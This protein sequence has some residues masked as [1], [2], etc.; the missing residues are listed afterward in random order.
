MKHKKWRKIGIALAIGGLLIPGGYYQTAYATGNGQKE[1]TD[2]VIDQNATG[3]ESKGKVRFLNATGKLS[4]QFDDDLLTAVVKAYNDEKKTNKAKEDITYSDLYTMTGVLDLSSTS[5]KKIP[6]EAFANCKFQEVKFPDTLETIGQSSFEH[7]KQLTKINIPDTL[8]E[9]GA[10]AFFDCTALAELNETN[11][12]PSKITNVGNQVF[13]SDSALKSVTIATDG[14]DPKVYQKATGIFA[15][16]SGLESIII[17]DGVSVIPVAAFQNSGEKAENGVTVSFGKDLTSILANAFENVNFAK[18]SK[19]D[20]SSCSALA[21][22]H[23]DAFE[24]AKNLTTVILPD[25]SSNKGGVEFDDR[26]FANTEIT[27]MNVAGNFKEEDSV[28]YIP[29][30]VTRLGIGCFYGSKEIAK[31]SLSPKVEILSDYLFDYCTSLAVIEQRVDKD[32]NCAVKEIGDCAF[33]GTAITNTEF[34][35]AMNQLETIGYQHIE[36]ENYSMNNGVYDGKGSSTNQQINQEGKIGT[37]PLGGVGD[38]NAKVTENPET[39]QKTYEGVAVGSEVFSDCYSLTKVVIPASVTSIAT[40]A[41]YHLPRNIDKIADN[42]KKTPSISSIEWQSDDQAGKRVIWS[43]AFQGNTAVTKIVLP[44][45]KKDELDIR[46]YAFSYDKALKVIKGNNTEDNVL[47][48]T[49][50]NLSKGVFYRCSA[51][52][53]IVVQNIA[54]KEESPAL[55]DYLF[56]HCTAMKKATL[57]ASIREIPKHCFYNVPLTSYSIGAENEGEVE[58]ISKIGNLAFLGN[59]FKTVDLSA[60]TGLSEIGAGAFAYIDAVNEKGEEG[61]NSKIYNNPFSISNAGGQIQ[62]VIL[63]DALNKEIN[64]SGALYLNSA[65]FYGNFY[66]STLTTT[67]AL[68]KYAEK[69]VKDGVFYVPSY[70]TIHDARAVFAAT[71]VSKTIWQVDIDPS[72]DKENQW[73]D[74]PMLLYAN[75]FM[76]KNSKDVLPAGNYVEN[77]GKGAFYASAVQ[78]ADLSQYTSLTKIGSGKLESGEDQYTGVFADCLL[79]NSVVLP[80]SKAEKFVL[81]DQTFMKTK[82][83]TLDAD[84]L[85]EEDENRQNVEDSL[86]IVDLGNIT[87]MGANAFTGCFKLKSIVLPDTL[88]EIPDNAFMNC[89]ALHN[90]DFGQVKKINSFAFQ[91]CK[92]L[93][94]SKQGDSNYQLPDT[95]ESIESSAFM[96]AGISGEKGLGTAVFGDKLTTISDSVF[97]S[98]ALTGVDFTNAKVLET[99]GRKA[100]YKSKLVNFEL[101]GTKV[102]TINSQVLA[103]CEKLESA[104]FGD[105]VETIA[106]GAIKGCPNFNSI[107]FASTTT[108][109]TGVFSGTET[110]NKEQVYTAQKKAYTIAV[111]VNA[112]EQ[113]IVAAERENVN[114]PYY[115]NK[116]GTSSLTHIVIGMPDETEDE[117]VK[118]FVKLHA[119]LSDGYYW[120]TP[121]KGNTYKIDNNTDYYEALAESRTTRYNKNDVDVVQLD[122]LKAGKYTIS[123]TDAMKFEISSEKTVTSTFTT[124]FNI[125]AQSLQYNVGIYKSKTEQEDSSMLYEQKIGTTEE[126]QATGYNRKGAIQCYYKLEGSDGKDA[127]AE[128]I[129]SYDVIVKSDDTAIVVPGSNAGVNADYDKET[130]YTTNATKTQNNVVTPRENNMYFW[131]VPTGVGSTTVTVYP[132]GHE[133]WKTTFTVNINSDINAIEVSVPDD[134]SQGAVVGNTF[135][136]FNSYT[137]LFDASVTSD[138]LDQAATVSNRGIAY[139]SDAP[140]YASVDAAGNVTILKADVRDKRVRITAAAQNA[141]NGKPVS[142]YVTVVIKGDPTATTQ[143]PTTQAPTTEKPTDNPNNANTSANQNS[144]NQGGNATDKK[145][146]VRTGQTVEDAASGT[147]VKVTKVAENG[148]GGEVAITTINN[149]NATKVSIPTTVMVEGVPYQVTEISSN[150]CSGFKK[151]KA[152]AIP[153][154]VKK[155]GDGAF[156]NCKKLKKVVIPKGVESIGSNA[157]YGCKSLKLITVKSTVLKSVGSNAFYGIHKKAKIKVPKKK[158]KVYK[159]I[160]SNKGQKKSVKIKK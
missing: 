121:K 129:D 3:N 24:G 86:E 155:I 130:G 57:P 4:D 49:I 31:V 87:E 6:D 154:S 26:A 107:T 94:F 128:W 152:V 23:A 13:G 157:F 35:L 68:E 149:K 91:N 133:D 105:E 145:P 32:K 50:L 8:K 40:R 83:A 9:L 150:L 14:S 60:Y 119:K 42:S 156:Q 90:V 97:A 22:F 136:I 11:A 111:I 84:D 117:S 103:G 127:N 146:S 118:E 43:G 85:K 61:Q 80:Q 20:F 140:E 108:V 123:V 139:T 153:A 98:S 104:S 82:N 29:D 71:A 131:L 58:K 39:K 41:F 124:L 120:Y 143:A 54:G 147:T 115:V 159:S 114:L 126:I 64:E 56:E 141:E 76:I 21:G 110:I 62:K 142:K 116:K 27:N 53:S 101:K 81:G 18:E 102:A 109:D 36:D 122:T 158:Y 112:P 45:T 138:T 12:L 88:A 92:N 137:N 89:I 15:G 73:K 74:I 38:S 99:I 46:A 44:D 96:S 66:M 100:F 72:V 7:C 151:L 134:Y 135:N 16:C 79:L 70:L 65:P 160:L 93:Y 37:L 1:I 33:R 59:A 144:S 63:P 48:D 25:Q 19:L 34:L 106:N 95:L 148:A 75:C 77:I 10:N 51:L 30:Y 78:N 69:G 28:I 132:K 67:E 2:N 113:T 55:G 5:I 52:P 125:E 17:G 47:P